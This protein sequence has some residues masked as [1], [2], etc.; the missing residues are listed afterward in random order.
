[1]AGHVSDVV[2]AGDHAVG[3]DQVA[4]TA[5]E[6]GELLA[7]VARHFVG[8]GDGVVG[9]AEQAERELLRLRER[10]VLRRCVVRRTEDGDAEFVE[11]FGPVTQGLSLDRST[12]G[13]GLRVPP[14]QHPASRQVSQVDGIAMLVLQHKTGGHLSFLQHATSVPARGRDRRRRTRRT[15]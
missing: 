13:C 15:A 2:G 4:V 5:R 7:D 3:I 14:Q 11:S 6:F 12:G 10:Q 1:M 8:G 9:V